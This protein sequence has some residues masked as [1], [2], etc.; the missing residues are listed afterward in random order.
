M[1]LECDGVREYLVAFYSDGSTL[2]SS[3]ICPLDGFK[4]HLVQWPQSRTV[5]PHFQVC[6]AVGRR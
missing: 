5:V 6:G 2:T 1:N 3:L 4:G